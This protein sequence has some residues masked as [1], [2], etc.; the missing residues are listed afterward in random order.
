MPHDRLY[1]AMYEVP[2][3]PIQRKLERPFR[4]ERTVRHD[5]TLDLGVHGDIDVAGLTTE[6]IKV[7]VVEQLRETLPDE[8]LGLTDGVGP[9]DTD[10]VAVDFADHG[11]IE[12]LEGRIDELERGLDP[13]S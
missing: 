8:A 13:G 1:V 3:R 10:I 11:P 9:A 2:G 6:Q 4:G 12:R 5:G 7:K